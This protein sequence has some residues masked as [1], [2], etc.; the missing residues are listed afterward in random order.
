M[1]NEK[2][3]IHKE[4]CSTF[5]LISSE[6]F[7]SFF[8]II[9]KI[10]FT[11][12][13]SIILAILFRMFIGEVYQVPSNSMDDTL[14][15]GDIIWV[16]KLKYGALLPS[17]LADVPFLGALF[18]SKGLSE[19]IRPRS[20]G[21]GSINKG[22]IIVFKSPIKEESL[23]LI[24]RCVG[25]PGDT[26]QIIN[27][28]IYINSKYNVDS[29]FCKYF[30]E[31]QEKLPELTNLL[32]KVYKINPAYKFESFVK[33]H[34]F[35]MNQSQANS[36][37]KKGYKLSKVNSDY[38]IKDIFPES[39]IGVWSIYNYGK[40][41]VPKI[42]Q[43]IKLTKETYEVYG[44]LI[45]EWEG[46]DIYIENGRYFIEDKA[47]NDYKFKNNYYFMIGDNRQLASDSR[48]FGFINEHLIEGTT[49]LV[50]TNFKVKNRFLKFIK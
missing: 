17:R 22:D 14:K 33:K 8:K 30:Y 36:L 24:K 34:G 44:D 49:N 25:I 2:S 9:L 29:E 19:N 47:I 18:S 6:R 42:G 10:G 46:V 50:L 28:D 26:I 48:H 5:P 45:R 4:Y 3:Y 40:I 39:K 20:V 11:F 43:S 1:I 37:A 38:K 32:Y 13:I 41:W 12:F 15:A 21:Y 27:N 16:Q 35:L 23:Q 31:S 7:G